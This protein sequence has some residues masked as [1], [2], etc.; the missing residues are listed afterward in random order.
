MSDLRNKKPILLRWAN[1]HYPPVDEEILSFKNVDE[2]VKYT[3][4]LENKIEET[5]RK[6]IE[7]ISKND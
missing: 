7:V 3:R 6:L 1:D 5:K 4:E 2:L